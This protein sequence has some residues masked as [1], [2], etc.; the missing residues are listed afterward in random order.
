MW[1]NVLS[2]VGGIAA[3]ALTSGVTVLVNRRKMDGET[4]ARWDALLFEKAAALAE[5]ARRLRHHAERY[6]HAADRQARLDK[7]AEAQ[8]NLRVTVEQLRL[9]GNKRVQ[10]AA[11]TV[12]HHGYAVVL[13][14][15]EDRDPRAEQYP[16]VLPV[17]RLNDALQE[18]YRAVRE[19]L[20]APDH[21]DVLHDDDFDEIVKG[22]RPLP[23]DQ[24]T[25]AV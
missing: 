6:P 17:R 23:P 20:R 5:A 10:V 25:Y 12:L 24:R 19:Q 2:F 8:E 14:Y 13:Q 15:T 3:V 21:A 16:G 1:S 18:F 9:V 4:R 22:L 7:V 11:R